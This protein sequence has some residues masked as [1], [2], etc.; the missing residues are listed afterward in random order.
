MH[1]LRSLRRCLPDAV[2][3]T[4]T[5]LRIESVRPARHEMGP[6][7]ARGRESAGPLYE[8]KMT[9]H[10]DLRES[11][12]PQLRRGGAPGSRLARRGGADQTNDSIDHHHPSL[13]CTSA[14]P[15]SAEEGS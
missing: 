12:P 5:G 8:V 3:R 9:I 14:L 11:S 1:V 7:K 4:H 10:C 13:G 2:P 6:A 15:S